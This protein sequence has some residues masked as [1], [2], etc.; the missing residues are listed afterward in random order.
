MLQPH[1][2]KILDSHGLLVARSLIGLSFLIGGVTMA[3]AGSVAIGGYFASVGVPFPVLA[4]Y[5]VVGLKIIAGAMLILGY[6]IG[7][8]AGMLAAFVILATYFG[9][10]DLSDPNNVTATL[11]NMAMLGGLLYVMAT[12][13]GTG[14]RLRV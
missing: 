1:H 10:R 9:H 3:Q 8:A 11:K 12:G 5:L 6:R 13:A 7:C 14:W 4:F 2:R